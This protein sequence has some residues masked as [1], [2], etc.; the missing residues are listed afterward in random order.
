MLL[1]LL[2]LLLLLFDGLGLRALREVSGL[3]PLQL[4]LLFVVELVRERS[5]P[6]ERHGSRVRESRELGR[7]LWRESR[8]V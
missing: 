6:P 7:V 2:L 4:C 8:Y 3:D 1:L 5:S